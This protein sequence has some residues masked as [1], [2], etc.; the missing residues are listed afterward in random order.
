MADGVTDAEPRA[1]VVVCPM[2]DGGEGTVT[3]IA[4]ATG[5]QVREEEASGPLPGQIVTARWAFLPP[6]ALKTPLLQAE[7][8]AVI[9]MAQASGL[10]LVPP[11][12]RDPF[13]VSYTHLRAHETRHDL[14]C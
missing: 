7:K 9:E 1:E 2:A 5:A 3:A 4:S 14:V 13:A 8:T 10:W 12:K 6:G 11:D